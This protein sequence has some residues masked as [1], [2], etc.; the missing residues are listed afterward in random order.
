MIP[1]C[2]SLHNVDTDAANLCDFMISSGQRTMA[3]I[4]TGVERINFAASP[5][6]I[7]AVAGTQRNGVPE[8]QEVRNSV[9]DLLENEEMNAL[10]LSSF[11]NESFPVSNYVCQNTGF[12]VP[13]LF[14]DHE[15]SQSINIALLSQIASHISSFKADLLEQGL[16]EGSKEFN[17]ALIEKLASFIVDPNGLNVVLTYVVPQVWGEWTVVETL[18]QSHRADC[19]EYSMLL[20]EFSRLA[21]IDGQFVQ[22]IKDTEIGAKNHIIVEFRLNPADSGEITFVDLTKP[23]PILSAAPGQWV[24]IPRLGMIAYYHMNLG[25]L[26][27][28]SITSK[29]VWDVFRFARGEY[30]TG[31]SLSPDLPLLYYS[32]GKL[33]NQYAALCDHG[34]LLPPGSN[35]ECTSQEFYQKAGQ[36]FTRTV[37][38]DPDNVSAANDLASLITIQHE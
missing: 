14:T 11:T 32:L 28:Q 25:L 36:Y 22:V 24:F 6:H 2:E 29:E 17:C 38:L 30:E 31:L 26:P 7:E 5:P 21:G 3:Q 20:Y 12:R 19:S 16:M 10:A 37:E 15:P 18:T 13:Y 1:A 35:Y 33:Y 27:P 4:D 23:N 8:V 34:E 9:L